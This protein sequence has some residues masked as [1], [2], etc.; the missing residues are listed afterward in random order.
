MVP[1]VAA[2]MGP[3]AA[4]TSYIA[5]LADYAP[6]V[7]G[8][9]SMALAGPPLVKAVIGEEIS[10][11][12]LGGSKIHCQISGVG[13]GEFVDDK[14]CLE[15][16][17]KYLSYFPSH[18]EQKPPVKAEPEN[19][20][21]SMGD[22]I[23][24][25]VPE[26]PRQG[27]DMKKVI[28]PIC[29]Y[30]DFFEIKPEFAPNMIVGFGRIKGRPV[31]FVAN[32]SLVMGGV[33]DVNAADKASRFMLSCDAFQIPLIFL[34]DCPGFMVGSQVEKAGIIRHGAKML[35]VVASLTVP[36]LSVV[37]RKSY[38]AGY[39][40]MCGKG[41]KPDFIVG[42]PTAEIS[43]MGAEG[44]VSIV[45]KNESDTESK[46]QKVSEYKANIGGLISA[47]QA[48]ID[49]IIDPR[50][51]RQILY[52]ALQFMQHKRAPIKTRKRGVMPV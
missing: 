31:G 4:G 20:G 2:V 47:K 37:I 34:H 27:F 5:A 22:D 49:D 43:L 24:S 50:E 29:D 12:D 48:H 23:L 28:R 10:T 18:C 15:A 51:T 41:L 26:N 36:K 21:M 14:S 16:I 17:R 19:I 40:V 33:I 9:S 44:A 13:D 11:E 39:F 30:N 1:Q 7:R 46:A 6:M 8:T 38:G 42:W 35:H 52:K 25:V 45:M 3:T 32:Q